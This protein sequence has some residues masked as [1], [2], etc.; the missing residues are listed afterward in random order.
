[1]EEP[2]KILNSKET[3]EKLVINLEKIPIRRWKRGEE[4]LSYEPHP[5]SPSVGWKRNETIYTI[6]LNDFVIGIAQEKG[7]DNL[8]YILII[9]KGEKILE[10]HR[11]SY[12]D[13]RKMMSSLFVKIDREYESYQKQR[14]IKREQDVVDEFNR[15]IRKIR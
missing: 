9:R 14:E 12:F 15:A 11:E 13:R 2:T 7:D 8:N 6:N 4:S 1:M 10:S 3:L 5:D